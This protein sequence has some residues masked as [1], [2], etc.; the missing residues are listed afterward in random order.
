MF[1]SSMQNSGSNTPTMQQQQQSMLTST[2]VG[3]PVGGAR[4]FPS[5]SE[6]TP[7]GSASS[8]PSTPTSA[9][10][11]AAQQQAAAAAQQAAQHKKDRNSRKTCQYC[12]KVRKDSLLKRDFDTLKYSFLSDLFS[13]TPVFIDQS[14]ECLPIA[15]KPN[16]LSLPRS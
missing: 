4:P 1:V 8:S 5:G 7:G 15:R 12:H 9:A 10:A 16:S 3:T 11:L 13:I 2:P 14:Q 6:G